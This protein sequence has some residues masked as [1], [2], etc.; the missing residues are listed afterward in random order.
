MGIWCSI[1]MS[2]LKIVVSHWLFTIKLK[3]FSLIFDKVFKI[4]FLLLYDDSDAKF[5]LENMPG[6]SDMTALFCTC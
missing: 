5:G 2:I 4:F 6:S 3:F 1:F